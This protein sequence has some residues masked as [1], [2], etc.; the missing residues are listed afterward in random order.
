MARIID[1]QKTK[2]FSE[3][4]RLYVNARN[5]LF[6]VQQVAECLQIQVASILIF[7]DLMQF[8]EGSKLDAT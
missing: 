8:D 7:T 4:A 3:A 6:V 5:R 1:N 2:T